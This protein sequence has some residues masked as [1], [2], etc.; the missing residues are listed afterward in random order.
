MAIEAASTEARRLRLRGESVTRW[1]GFARAG[2]RSE[3]RT[4]GHVQFDVFVNLI[5]GTPLILHP[6]GDRRCGARKSATQA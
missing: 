6:A 3:R 5:Q 2:E 1:R 4:G